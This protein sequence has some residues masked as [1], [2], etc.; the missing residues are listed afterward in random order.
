MDSGMSRARFH[1]ALIVVEAFMESQGKGRG[2]GTV[3]RIAASNPFVATTGK[4]TK[5]VLT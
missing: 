4:L 1:V 2:G 5:V 3:Q